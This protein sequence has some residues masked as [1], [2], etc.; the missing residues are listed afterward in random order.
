MSS[1]SSVLLIE[2]N[3]GDARLVT[4]Y[5][6]E[7]FGD[8]CEVLG[9][10]TLAAGLEALRSHHV[11]LVLLDL[12]LPD[13]TGLDTFY[14]VHAQ[15]PRTPVVI[16]TGDDDDEQATEALRVG[17]EDYL[18]KK[19]ADSV[20][21]I[22]TMRHAVQRRHAAEAL[23]SSE[24]RYHTLVETMEE[25]IVQVDAG[26]CIRFANARVADMLGLALPAL[27]GR[28]LLE[29]VDP[30]HRA[31]AAG[32]LGIA[33][34][35][36]ASG[37]LSLRRG[38]GVETRVIAAVGRMT[39]LHSGWTEAVVMLADIT[40]RQL[41]EEELRRLKM[42]LEERVAERTAQLEA[43]N[44]DLE[45]FNHSVAHDL[46]APL[47]A[48]LGFA[49]ILQ[50]DAA[51]LLSTTHQR[52]LQFIERS[53]Q[54]MNDLIGGLLSLARVARQDLA[55]EALD[56]S[57]MAAG[58]VEHLAREQP[59]HPV[60]WHIEPGMRGHGDPALM[61][62]VLQNL[63]HNA[64]KYTTG[65]AR[66]QVH[67]GAAP[68]ASRGP[69]YFVRDNGVGFDMAWAGKL[70]M[71]FQRLPSAQVFAGTGLGLA[72]VRRIVERHGGHIWAESQPG[73]STTF[74]F[75]LQDLPPHGPGMGA[76]EP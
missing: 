61:G 34:G 47:N 6:G 32:L 76:A 67:F 35:S 46:R 60:E 72:T 54:S 40:G 28:R 38:N 66:P 9:A 52:H 12:S 2:D 49:S 22:R 26:G 53:A 30:A 70:F 73:V 48:I 31:A 64:W 36:R 63:L 19:H 25:G 43:A 23:R 15:A 29:S 57:A 4:E 1:L 59:R 3:P 18:A 11:D 71:P 69:V 33:P 58:I 7:R 14:Q 20:A 65:A 17:A 37:E 51:G 8:E 41:A 5:L 50:E 13:S 62:I 55:F 27:H 21:L 56:L 45:A 44:A 74:F 24:T 75:S 68:A 10:R 39:A 16:L 42:Q